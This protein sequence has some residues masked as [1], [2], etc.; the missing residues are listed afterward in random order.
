MWIFVAGY[1]VIR[2]RDVDGVSCRASFIDDNEPTRPGT[3]KR[4]KSPMR[5]VAH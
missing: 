5:S 2:S 1:G 4:G 3:R